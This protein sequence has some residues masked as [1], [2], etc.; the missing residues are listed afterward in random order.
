VNHLSETSSEE[1]E[2]DTKKSIS[3][4]H[5]LRTCIRLALLRMN[6]RLARPFLLLLL[7]MLNIDKEGAKTYTETSTER[8]ST[9][10]DAKSTKGKIFS[11]FTLLQMVI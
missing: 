10:R 11:I 4:R 5:P 8:M 7:R 1:R 6:F 3:P 9:Q 2:T